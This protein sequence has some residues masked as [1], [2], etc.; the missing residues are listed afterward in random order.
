MQLRLTRPAVLQL[1][2]VSVNYQYIHIQCP[3]LPAVDDGNDSGGV[4]AA[5]AN[6]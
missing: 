3:R 2:A 1:A 5:E 6:G 4:V